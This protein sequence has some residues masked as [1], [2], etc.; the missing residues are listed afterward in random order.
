MN[1]AIV[2]NEVLCIDAENNNLGLMDRNR[3]ISMAQQQGLDL[4]QVAPAPMGKAPTCRIVDSGK[5]KFDLSKKKKE[6]EKRQ[7]ENEIQLKEIKFRPITEENDLKI[8]A[9][10]AEEF[11]AEGCKVKVSIIFKKKGRENTSAGF[12]AKAQET[13]NEFISLISNGILEGRALREGSQLNCY[14]LPKKET[15][16]P[17]KPFQEAASMIL[18]TTLMVG[19]DKK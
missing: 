12:F 9:R 18:P 5:Y 1:R 8:K 19:Q 13:L 7:R 16:E 4:V 10:K 14:L 6:N 11:L 3:A 17:R 15:P 2:A